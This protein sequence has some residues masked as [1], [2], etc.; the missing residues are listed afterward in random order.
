MIRRQIL[1]RRCRFFLRAGSLILVAF[2]AFWLLFDP[3]RDSGSTVVFSADGAVVAVG[4]YD[5]TVRL[6]DTRT[7]SLLW[8]ARGHDD[9]IDCAVFSPSRR[10]L[11]AASR[12]GKT[13]VW[14]VVSGCAISVRRGLHAKCLQFSHDE[15]DIFA[16]KW[17]SQGNLGT[18]TLQRWKVNSGPEVPLDLR[19]TK[20]VDY[21]LGF[22][23]EN[24]I[25]TIGPGSELCIL[26]DARRQVIDLDGPDS[27]TEVTAIAQ[28]SDE[29]QLAIGD[30][31]GGVAIWDT[32]TW[33]RKARWKMS[34]CGVTSL[35]FSSDNRYLAGVTWVGLQGGGAVKV[36]D[37]ATST[38]ALLFEDK[39]AHV[40]AVA[41]TPEG[42]VV[43]W[44][45]W[46]RFIK[47]AIRSWDIPPSEKSGWR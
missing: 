14:D 40:G 24:G 41:F 42:K 46:G 20:N 33:E 18:R 6:W 12:D 32:L 10:M 25:A 11:A 29:R 34:E 4:G 37:T 36:Y 43:G 39:N 35:C 30:E 15:E 47:N 17:K 16:G 5:G 28:S 7:E 8:T 1:Y 31:S 9:A 13:I 23:R 44:L 27:F 45:H 26:K 19:W 2:V 3:A 21:I 22:S 38:E